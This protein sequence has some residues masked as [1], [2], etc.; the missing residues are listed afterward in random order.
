MLEK[1]KTYKFKII[2]VGMNFEGIAKAES[3]LTVFIPGALRDEIVEA[4]I[5]KLNSSYAL[6]TIERIVQASD[7]RQEAW[8]KH[9]NECGGC[10]ARHTSYENTLD[11]KMQN[12]IN[13]FKKQD[14]D[15]TKLEDIYGMGVPYNY[16]NKVQYPV[17]DI[18][19]KISMG[20]FEMASHNLV[21]ID[22]CLIQDEQIHKV[23]TKL[24]EMVKSEGFAG[25]NEVEG[26][27][28]IRNIMVRRGVHTGEIMC[29]L[30]INSS[31]LIK[32]KRI[33]SVVNQITTK[34]KEITSFI[35]NINDKKTNV[36][37]SDYNV[38]I[39]G[40]DYIIDYIGD[41]KFKI[42]ADSFFQVN[43]LQA[44]VLYNVLKEKMNLNK[45]KTM[46]E[47]Y[48]GV[49][50]IG[51]FLANSV[52]DIYS[53][54]IVQSA[55]RAAIENARINEVNNIININGD[56]TKET[57][58]LAK[59]GNHFDYIV[60]DPPR[61][62]LDLEGIDLILKLKPEKIGYVSCNAA[63]CARDLRLLCASGYEVAS[64]NL[65]D[66]FPWTS[67][68]ECCSVLKLKE[69]AEI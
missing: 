53:V 3:G 11:I 24:F 9:Y 58:N 25:Y 39:Y 47:L 67:H 29:V 57:L 18:D 69:S 63:T 2:D 60:V 44:E 15:I 12:V 13:T 5:V 50:S 22:S 27:G 34:F 26:T 19:G 62:G 41:Y 6:G 20:M 40:N 10:V 16:R 30:V 35:L 43:T 31:T 64:I 49:G 17:R 61:K 23:A 38:C 51:V 1:G 45:E 59:K 14:L 48:S 65:V 33:L 52:K 36:I 8:C 42:T 21:K 54:E 55:T 37:L 66:M 28:D 4:K 68:V 56:A 7:N 46:L 32:D